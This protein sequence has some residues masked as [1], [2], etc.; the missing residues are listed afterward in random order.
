MNRPG[1]QYDPQASPQKRTTIVLKITPPTAWIGCAYRI[2]A[3]HFAASCLR[4][5]RAGA[6]RFTCTSSAR[7][8]IVS[9]TILM[10]F[11]RAMDLTAA[12][13]LPAEAIPRP[14]QSE[15][16]AESFCRM[17]PAQHALHGPSSNDQP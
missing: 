2:E 15:P 1:R 10:E 11:A 7:S 14:I 17:P 5:W 12:R 6:R 8:M 13:I 9:V 16:G 3:C 4:G